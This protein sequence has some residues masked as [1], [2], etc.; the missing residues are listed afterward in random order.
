MEKDGRSDGTGPVNRLVTP[1]TTYDLTFLFQNVFSSRVSQ[2]DRVLYAAF[3][4]GW[5]TDELLVA[6]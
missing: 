6:H 3:F 4:V 5:E 1:S 2:V